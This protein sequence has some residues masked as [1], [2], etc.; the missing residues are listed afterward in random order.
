M[1]H[2][3]YIVIGAGAT[4]LEIAEGLVKTGHP[5]LLIEKDHLG[6]DCTNFGGVPSKSLIASAHIAHNIKSAEKYGIAKESSTFDASKV[7][8][9]TQ[10][11][12]DKMRDHDKT[13]RLSRRGVRMVFGIAEFID[14]HTLRVIQRGG[15]EICFSAKYIIIAT[16]SSP[17]IP[18]I[19][20]I[21]SSPYLTHET[22]L[23]LTTVPKTIAFIGGGPIG[24][25]L[26]Q[27]F[28]RLGAKVHLFLQSSHILP[29]EDREVQET[30]ESV[31]EKEGI[32]FHRG[33]YIPKI[34]Y[35]EKQFH[36]CGISVD[37]L[38]VTAGRK[39]NIERLHL[40][41]AGVR[42]TERRIDTDTC[43]RTSQ[44][45]IFA[46]GDVA[47]KQSYAENQ[48]GAVLSAL[49]LPWHKKLSAQPI[50][51]TTCTD[52]EVAS[53]GISESEAIEKFGA[54]KIA[55]YRVPLGNID[56]AV[57]NSEETG[58]IKVVTKKWSSKILGATIVAPRAGEMLMEISLAMKAKIPFK[59]LSD[60]IHPHASYGQGIRKAA[61]LYLTQTLL[62]GYEKRASSL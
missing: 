6:G 16:G 5:V 13:K 40:E 34:D 2:V 4:G 50:P 37:K 25:E 20:G 12:V 42:H 33:A 29:G 58:F 46:V 44:S 62:G 36:L 24:I 18:D 61:D 48:A 19:P 26:A 57:T 52:P 7:F 8:A 59:R 27:A 38:A 43:G 11:I 60:L 31:L 1:E 53:V 21:F 45:H 23:S 30:I 28:S 15:T 49:L 55:I 56:R 39:P 3:T 17:Q 32:V 41:A 14:A 35:R 54:K 9:R 47:G 22:I 51:R 10:K